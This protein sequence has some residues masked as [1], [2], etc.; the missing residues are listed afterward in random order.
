MRRTAAALVSGCLL[1]L[2]ACTGGGSSTPSSAPGEADVVAWMD[3]VCAAVGPTSKLLADEPK[4]D[5][6]DQAALK[7][8]LSDWLGTKVSSVEKSI[9]ELKA[10]E[11]GPHPKSK[12]LVGTAESGL[13][14]VRT[15][16]ADAKSRVDSAADETQ[17]V[18]AFTEMATKASEM[19]AQASNVQRKL[20]ETGLAAAAQKA[21]NCK[22]L[23]LSASSAPTS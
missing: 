9:N 3:K 8:G 7:S 22:D 18:T 12:E 6:T 4:F 11:D 2:T 15:L 20:G 13:G 5:L 19:D 10:L 1:T 17:I 23:E 14:Q 21:G 16:L